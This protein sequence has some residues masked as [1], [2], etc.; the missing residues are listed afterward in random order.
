M[1]TSKTRNSS[2]STGIRIV[3]VRVRN[4]RSLKSVNV[5]LGQMTIL[6]GE[7]NSG[8]TSFLEAMYAAIGGVRRGLDKDDIYT[9]AGEITLPKDRHIIVD[10]LIR[11]TSDTGSVIST[12]PAG[13][14]WTKVFGNGIML[15]DSD[16]DF[17]AIRT[18]RTWQQ[19]DADYDVKRRYLKEWLNDPSKIET[20]SVDTSSNVRAAREPLTLFFMNAKR[21][22]ADDMR[23]HDSI[24]GKLT[25]DLG[26]TEDQ[27]KEIEESLSNLN[28]K[29]INSSAVLGHMTSDLQVMNDLVAGED[30]G[31]EISPIASVMSSI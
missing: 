8:K 17:V 3:E 12:F 5:P 4:F 2:L 30:N 1:S 7:N 24:W 22:I 16:E 10:L 19:Y 28:T 13:G 26:L 29:M 6:I 27:T 20:A 31:V 18:S 14:F 11:P 9:T 25:S 21:D 23:R 15:D